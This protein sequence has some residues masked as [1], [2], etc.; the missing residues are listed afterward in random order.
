MEGGGQLGQQKKRDAAYHKVEEGGWITVFLNLK[1][2]AGPEVSMK[3]TDIE[4]RSGNSWKTLSTSPIT[5]DS[6]KVRAG[7]IIIA[8]NGVLPGVYDSLRFV[9][10]EAAV[11][12]GSTQ[13]PLVLAEPK[14]QM[15]LNPG[16]NV[17]RGDSHSFFVTW[18]VEKSVSAPQGFAAGLNADLQAI[19]LLNNLLFVTC[20]ELD[21]VFVVRT[22]KNWVISSIGVTGKPTYIDTDSR[23]E[24]LYVLASEEY[25]IKVID[26]TAFK[27]IDKYAVQLNSAPQFM[28]LTPDKNYAFVLDE[29]GKN[30]VKVDLST[31]EIVNQAT[32][33]FHP[34]YATYLVER[35]LLAVSAVET[36]NVYLLNPDNFITVGTLPV[37]SRP[38]GLLEFGDILL[39]AESGSNSVAAYQIDNRIQSAITSVPFSP[40]RLLLKSNQ[41]YATSIAGGVVTI[42]FP[43]Q[44]L[45]SREI[46]V[47]GKPLEISTSENNRWLYVGNG[48]KEGVTVIDETS[49]RIMGFIELETAPLGMTA[50]D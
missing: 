33:N 36:N 27:L 22:D 12:N 1:E 41:L 4:V 21:T 7:Q 37:A 2:A 38:E 44:L 25:A 20:P 8:R 6:S 15:E 17:S 50:I 9:I 19:P 5:I 11:R 26:L 29:R 23:G 45:V 32:L 46:V 34:R 30:I 18:D 10:Q 28:T 42:M 39:V 16:I 14:V 43:G 3:I 13:A 24:R 40:M 48:E 49:K 35:R 47:G 31:G